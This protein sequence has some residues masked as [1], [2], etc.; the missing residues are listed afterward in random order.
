MNTQDKNKELT[1]VTAAKGKTG[2]RVVK[3]LE[4]MGKAVRAV[5][6]ST[7]I[8]F[9]WNDPSTWEAALEGV[10]SAYLVYTPDLSLPEAPG[11][12]EKLIALGKSKSLKKVVLLSGRG[13]AGAR[14]SEE[15]VMRSG[16]DW[17]VVR[18]S[19]FNQNFSEGSFLPM[20][21]EGHLMMP[22]AEYPEPFIDIDDIADVA[23]AALT[24]TGHEGQIYEVTGPE[25][26]N[27]QQVVDMISQAIGTPVKFTPLTM[28]QFREGLAQQ[29]VP[30]DYIDLLTYLMGLGEDGRNKEVT[31]GVQRALGRPASSFEAYV[32]KM[33]KQGAWGQGVSA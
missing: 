23:T 18:A 32:E 19:W 12:I 16:L 3:R 30:Q 1:L 26:L 22:Q 14:R 27:Y 15:V 28:D 20:I 33:V 13:E 25:S 29:Q 24:E 10:S 21:L 8:S 6:R 11:N 9:D 5:S 7:E 17:T 4:A 2:K 31:D